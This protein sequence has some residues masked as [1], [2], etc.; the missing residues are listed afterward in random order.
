MS[1]PIAI[2]EDYVPISCTFHDRLEDYAVRG[3]VIPV[4]FMKDG[5]L[6]ETD[7]SISDVFAKGGA[8]FAKLKL[9]SG[10]EVLVRLDRLLAVNGFDL[11]SSC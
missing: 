11:P 8:D 9:S 5:N 4:R 1:L 7:A 6:T 3:S 2:N 10:E